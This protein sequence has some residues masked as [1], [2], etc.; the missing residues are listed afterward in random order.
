MQ[1]VPGFFSIYKKAA[2]K[3]QLVIKTKG[4]GRGE[5]LLRRTVVSYL[6]D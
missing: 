4:K 1:R 5:N 6:A 2:D 3:R